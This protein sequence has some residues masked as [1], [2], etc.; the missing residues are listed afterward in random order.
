MKKALAI[1]AVL[2]VGSAPA[3]ANVHDEGDMQKKSAHYFSKMDK[4]GDGSVS[5]AESDE[6][7]RQLFTQAD[8]NKDGKLTSQEWMDHKKKEKEAW[9]AEMDKESNVKDMKPGR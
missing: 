9:K 7:G 1:A 5:Q 3:L 8:A 2:A 6:Y 4:N